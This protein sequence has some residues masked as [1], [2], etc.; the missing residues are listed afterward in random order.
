[1]LDLPFCFTR[2]F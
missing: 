2:G 1:V